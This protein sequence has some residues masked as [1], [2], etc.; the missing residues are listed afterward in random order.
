LAA[1]IRIPAV[2]DDKVAM[3]ATFC[4]FEFA[5]KEQG[6]IRGD[7]G[8][9]AWADWHRFEREDC[10]HDLPW[11]LSRDPDVRHLLDDPPMKHLVHNGRPTWIQTYHKP[12]DTVRELLSAARAV[13][14]N[15]FHGG[16]PGDSHRE[17]VLCRA[18]QKVLVAC[19]ERHNR[20]RESFN[21]R[22]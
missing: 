20:L 1:E 9:S 15:L 2:S 14:N 12:L 3:F 5:L 17:D 19:L 21:G 22:G 13:R 11:A 10:L 8:E 7:E 18:A 4:R 6:Y 16:K